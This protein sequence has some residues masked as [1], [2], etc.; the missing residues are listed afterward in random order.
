MLT[1]LALIPVEPLRP[2]ALRLPLAALAAIIAPIGNALILIR[3][4]NVAAPLYGSDEIA[5]W[6]SARALFTGVDRS[7]FNPYLQQV[8][9][10][11][12]YLMVGWLAERPD[13]AFTMRLFNYIMLV[14]TA[15]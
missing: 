10:D 11:L 3:T 4:A 9:S 6:H 2:S 14:L 12:F 8:N 15:W 13:G 1:N 7:T 5:Y